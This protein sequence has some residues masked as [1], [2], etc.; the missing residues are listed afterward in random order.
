MRDDHEEPDQI[1]FD[2][3]LSVS[4]KVGHEFAGVGSSG[5]LVSLV[6]TQGFAMLFLI[7]VVAYFALRNLAGASAL[8]AGLGSGVLGAAVLAHG[9]NGF[10]FNNEGGGWEYPA[11]WALTLLVQSLLGGGKFAVTKD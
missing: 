10:W 2:L 5:T 11:F 7:P 6:I 8:I 9:P 1:D 3:G 4:D